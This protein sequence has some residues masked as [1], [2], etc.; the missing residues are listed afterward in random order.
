MKK[1][2]I[3]QVDLNF[4]NSGGG[5]TASVTTILSAK[6]IDGSHGL[7]TVIGDL[8]EIGSFSNEK[9]SDIL[10]RFICTEIT[11]NADPVKTTLSRNYVDKTSLI[12]KSIMV[13]V[14]G[15]N[16]SPAEGL[17]FGGKTEG[18]G[19]VPYFSEVSNSPLDSFPSL[20]PKR[21]DSVIAA[22]R[23]YNY[24]AGAK[25]DGTKIALC[26][27][28][29]DLIKELSLN[30]DFVNDD[31]E[32][33]PDLAQYELKY[34]YTI[35]DVR[36][37]CDLAGVAVIGLPQADDVLF[38]TSGT[39]ESV[40]SNVASTLGCFWYVDPNNGDVRFINTIAAVQLKP[41]NYTDTTNTELSFE[42]VISA[43]YSES[44][45][46][47][48]VV[49]SYVGSAEKPREQDSSGPD[50]NRP[51]PIFFK[52]VD[53]TV[54]WADAVKD[55]FVGDT[56]T[57]ENDMPWPLDADDIKPFFGLF[58]QEQDTDVFDKFTYILTHLN[59]PHKKGEDSLVKQEFKRQLEFGRVYNY[60]PNNKQTWWYGPNITEDGPEIFPAA[61]KEAFLGNNVVFQFQGAEFDDANPSKIGK[62]KDGWG[63]SMRRTP[64][65]FG[66][67][68]LSNGFFY[69]LLQYKD[70]TRMGAFNLPR[71]AIMP[72]P[73]ETKLYSFLKAFFAV[74]GGI[75]ISNGYSKYKALRMQ[76]SN[77]NN[78]TIAGPYK[79][80]EFIQDIDELS[81]I[82][83]YMTQLEI[84]A[85]QR[86]IKNLKEWTLGASVAQKGGSLRSYYFIGLKTIAKL[87]RKNIPKEEQA[88]DTPRA[89]LI[90]FS[91][92]ADGVEYLQD[93]LKQHT[94]YIGGPDVGD[95]R[96]YM[97]IFEMM[98][99][100]KIN[101]ELAVGEAL[102]AKKRNKLRL[103]YTRSK[104][105]VNKLSEEGESDEDDEI[106]ES[107][108]SSQKESDLADRYDLRT[109]TVN[110]PPYD[111]LNNLSLAASSGS[112]VE[113]KILK[114]LR[115]DFTSPKDTPRSSSRT[116]YGLHSPFIAVKNTAMP[117]GISWEYS[118]L[119][120]SVSITVG[121]GGIQTT[122]N[123]SSIK[124]IP[125]SQN[126]L[127]NRGME[128]LT[129]Q[130]TQGRMSATQRNA[131]KL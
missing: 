16:C 97:G 81:I 64:E 60:E 23:I 99:Q 46:T 119:I 84:P 62:G 111:L 6:N 34:G 121:V 88:D 123:E 36:K 50:E 127:M 79:G 103:E 86:T 105:R 38:E 63:E 25:F 110:A 3:S 11:T 1:E 51:R 117:S 54:A 5:H 114:G 120:N 21:Y 32:Q 109:Y 19:V 43:S 129:P 30:L 31:Y 90:D 95:E 101:Y 22:G 68:L 74:A 13:L 122:I 93:P 100:S 28:N 115:S 92:L 40:L 8:G 37:M 108:D 104:T 113:I 53:L 45:V 107:G 35:D 70:D 48:Q 125:P 96:F 55:L 20:D 87:E 77:T 83:D 47:S 44:K 69:R 27:N 33:S 42:N 130:P 26:Y 29:K 4:T 17:N 24:E 7:G 128:A 67:H 39:L 85:E 15:I 49:N 71:N 57:P 91:Q 66:G 18:G 2:T 73:S 58:N 94:L 116:L 52:R 131:L 102:P 65:G 56:W 61:A 14:R 126:V 78:V 98:K 76:F 112:T 89:K 10:K 72:K 59:Y 80:D 106:A 124:L 118:P 75:Y 12:L 9:I 41:S 82:N